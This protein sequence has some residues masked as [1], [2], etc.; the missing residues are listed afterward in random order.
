MKTHEHIESEDQMIGSWA[1]M[2][3]LHPGQVRIPADSAIRNHIAQF[4][5]PQNH[6]EIPSD[7]KRKEKAIR[8]IAKNIGVTYEEIQ[9][10]TWAQ[11][12]LIWELHLCGND[13]AANMIA[14]DIHLTESDDEIHTLMYQTAALHM[15]LRLD[16]WGHEGLDE[17]ELASIAQEI[18]EMN[19]HWPKVSTKWQEQWRQKMRCL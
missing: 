13:G 18:V 12:N 1:E 9:N 4:W 7:A 2:N 10:Y 19:A 17:E 5:N 16:D 11:H 3:T 14:K 8:H 15:Y 6:G